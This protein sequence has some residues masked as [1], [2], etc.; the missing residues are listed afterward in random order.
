[1]RLSLAKR[2]DAAAIWRVIGPTIRVGET[3][4]LPR[5]MT[6]ADAIEYWM[7]D[8]NATFVAEVDEVIVGTYYMRPNQPGAGSH[9]CNCGYITGEAA[10]G[11][12]VARAMCAHSIEEARRRGYR[13][14]QFNLVVSTNAGALALWQAMGF[15]IV[16]RLPGAFDHPAHGYV[17]ALVMFRSL[18]EGAT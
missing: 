16:G 10:R 2:S 5:G 17:D 3:Y 11:R 4:P 12:G 6:E 7:A 15:D 13:G 8:E 1:M 14:M 18:V 9:I